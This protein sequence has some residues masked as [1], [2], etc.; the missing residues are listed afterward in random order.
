MLL[1]RLYSWEEIIAYHILV[2]EK[3]GVFVYKSMYDICSQLNIS[4][5]GLYNVINKLV[6][7]KCLEKKCNESI[8]IIVNREHLEDLSSDVAAYYSTLE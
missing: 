6:D 8:L 4:R 7:E 3:D 1:E 2:N 5:K